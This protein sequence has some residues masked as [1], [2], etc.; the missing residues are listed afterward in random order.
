MSLSENILDEELFEDEK[1]RIRTVHIQRVETG[2]LLLCASFLALGFLFFL[3]YGMGLLSFLEP[4][5]V[6]ITVFWWRW[7]SIKFDNDIS[8]LQFKIP[9]F[10]SI[11]RV[12]TPIYNIF[13]IS[14]LLITYRVFYSSELGDILGPEYLKMLGLRIALSSILITSYLYYWNITKKTM[15]L[16]KK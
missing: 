2:V 14:S 13:I 4:V 8:I 12:L 16:I 11:L 7:K 10:L 5:L 1:N 3:L 9:L 6:F 15:N